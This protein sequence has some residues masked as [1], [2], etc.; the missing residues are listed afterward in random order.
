[1]QFNLMTAIYFTQALVP[2]KKKQK[3]KTVVCSVDHGV[4]LNILWFSRLQT[5]TNP[6]SFNLLSIEVAVEIS[7]TKPHGTKAFCVACYCQR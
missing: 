4:K 3:K 7:E 6:I 1:M 5:P 2:M